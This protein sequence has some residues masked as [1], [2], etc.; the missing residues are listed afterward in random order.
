MAKIF[1][2]GA[3]GYIGGEA[4]HAIYN[5]HPEYNIAA[6]VRD[7][8]KAAQITKAYPNVRTILG[9]LGDSSLIS[10]EVSKADIVLNLAATS[11]LG[12]AQAIQQGL[13]AGSR[14]SPGYWLQMSGA[15]LLSCEEIANKRFGEPS[16]KVFNDFNGIEDIRQWIKKHPSRAVDNAVLNASAKTPGIKTALVVGPVIYGPGRGPVNQRSI[17]TPELAK[18]IIRRG[19]AW[20]VGKGQSVWD[21]VH[22]QDLGDIFLRLVERAAKGDDSKPYW[23]ENGI[24]FT[25]TGQLPFSELS[26]RVAQAANEQGYI[27]TQEV[28]ALS[29]EEADKLFP[30]ATFLLA[31]N[32]RCEALRARELLGWSPSQKSLEEEIPE[33]VRSEGTQLVGIPSL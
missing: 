27:K 13:T 4:L 31:T 6:L 17:Q 2:T 19:K 14:K 16:D 24:Y 21:N 30:H 22:V 26:S 9:D 32:A 10:D 29:P 12:S 25:G 33:T 28:D 8:G 18:T 20:Q 23:N 5:S 3:S 7:V 15:T 1:L 11:H